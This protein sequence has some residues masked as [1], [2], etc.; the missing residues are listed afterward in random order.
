MIAWNS[1]HMHHIK[2]IL[3][4]KSNFDQKSKFSWHWT[5]KIGDFNWKGQGEG[6]HEIRKCKNWTVDCWPSGRPVEESVNWFVEAGNLNPPSRFIFHL[7]SSIPWRPF[8][9]LLSKVSFGK[10]SDRLQVVDLIL[11]RLEVRVL[12]WNP[13]F[14][15]LGVI[16]LCTAHLKLGSASSPCA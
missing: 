14:Q 8:T 4:K 3:G 1:Y 6:D 15:F 10:I 16:S 2:I 11:G 13:G 12:I 5:S 9:S 7:F